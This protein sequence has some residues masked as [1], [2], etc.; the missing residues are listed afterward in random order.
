MN[1]E[2]GILND[3]VIRMNFGNDEV[4]LYYNNRLQPSSFNIPCSI[5]N[6]PF[7]IKDVGTR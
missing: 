4:H 6:I 1:I 3:E 7:L 5:F 2:Q